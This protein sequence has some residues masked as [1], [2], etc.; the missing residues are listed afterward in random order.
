MNISYDSV[1]DG[2]LRKAGLYRAT[3]VSK[4]KSKKLD[5]DS[6]LYVSEE[7]IID[8]TMLVK[9]LSGM[10]LS[11]GKG[12]ETIG[13]VELRLFIT[14]QMGVS[15]DLGKV[16]KYC[17]QPDKLKSDRDRTVNYGR[18]APTYRMEFDQDCAPLDKS[19][20]TREQTIMNK[21]R[22]GTK[23]WAI[24][25]FHY[26]SKGKDSRTRREH[27]WQYFTEAITKQNLRLTFDNSKLT[28]TEPQVLVFDDVPPLV[29]GTEPEKKDTDNSSR[30]TSSIPPDKP[31]A[32][33]KRTPQNVLLK[34][35]SL[36]KKK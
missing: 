3:K 22:P 11:Q 8:T 19:K 2:I 14:R 33:A 34:G 26:R 4:L 9:S 5:I 18:I 10:K 35:K 28:K 13:T 36:P 32:L 20:A 31:S 30:S 24:F 12:P 7:G 1:I 27:D 15:H 23:P 25:R 17:D 6:F 21:Q 16:A 29:E